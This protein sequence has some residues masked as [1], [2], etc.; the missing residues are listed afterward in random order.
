MENDPL[1]QTAIRRAINDTVSAQKSTKFMWGGEGVLA[2]AGGAWLAHVA[3]LGASTLE[4]VARSVIGGLGGLV[5]AILII[6]GWN[7]F[8]APYRQRNE[9]RILL[10][11]RPKP[12]PLGNRGDLLRVIT[13][14]RIATIEFVE[15]VNGLKEWDRSNPNRVNI[16]AISAI[17][18][19]QHRQKNAYEAMEREILVA[20]SDYEPIL[21]PLYL[22]MQSSA[23]LSASPTENKGTL[24][25]YKSELEKLITET[26]NRIDELNPQ[27][28]HKE[29]SQT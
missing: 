22:F 10:A 13:E 25:T 19:A 2:A 1:R 28:S 11:A 24:L 21:K 15:I 16:E 6:F 20:G 14:A 26:R 12:K 8:R 9:A 17:E 18:V 5:A 4:I 23:I 27:V 3:P 29:S 7:L